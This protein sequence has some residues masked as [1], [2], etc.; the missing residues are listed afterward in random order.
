MASTPAPT[1]PASSA[2]RRVLDLQVPRGK[3]ERP[4][5]HA[6]A[7][8]GQEQRPHARRRRQPMNTCDGLK[9][10]HRGEHLA[11]SGC[12]A[13]WMMALAATSPVRLAWATSSAV[14]LPCCRRLV[15]QQRAARRPAPPA[16]PCVKWRARPAIT[17]THPPVAAMAKRGPTTGQRR[18][19]PHRRPNRW[20]RGR[21]R[22]GTTI[23]QPMPVPILITRKFCSAALQAATARPAA[24]RLTSLST[25]T[26]RGIVFTQVVAD[27]EPPQSGISGGFTSWPPLEVHRAWHTH[28]DG[29]DLLRRQR[30]A[31]SAAR[32]SACACAPAPRP[33]PGAH[34]RLRHGARARSGRV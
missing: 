31:S 2:Q 14:R 15:G 18:C 20:R 13:R 22:R 6:L 4:L 21:P 29:D 34:R 1:S 16:R 11:R 25:N 32:A 23:P 7:H 8:R 28:A 12:P 24:I 5:V 9:I 33:A 10:D 19:G 27:R 3:R 17:S 26:G 30:A